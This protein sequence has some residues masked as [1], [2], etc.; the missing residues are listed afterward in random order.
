MMRWGGI[1]RG[2]TVLWWRSWGWVVHIGGHLPHKVAWGWSNWWRSCGHGGR[3][4]LVV[5]QVWCPRGLGWMLHWVADRRRRRRRGT[6]VLLRWC[7]HVVRVGYNRWL[8]RIVPRVVM[9]GLSGAR[10]SSVRLPSGR[11][12]LDGYG[13]KIA[14]FTSCYRGNAERL[15]A[16]SG[17]WG[18]GFMWGWWRR[19]TVWVVTTMLEWVGEVNVVLGKVRWRHAVS[20]RDLGC[21]GQMHRLLAAS[22]RLHCPHVAV[23]NMGLQVTL[24]EVS[25]LASRHNTAHVEGTTLALLDALHWI[26]AIVQGEAENTGKEVQ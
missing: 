18:W 14:V 21:R 22:R 4:G 2:A 11:V 26:C 9:W 1:Y 13:D 19:L 6:K 8:A 10:P 5:H 16:K 23:V 24:G 20:F 15:R 12:I 25:A 7:H 17:G 3:R